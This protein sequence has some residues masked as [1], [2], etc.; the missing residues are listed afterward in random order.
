MNFIVAFIL[1]ISGS[2]EKEA[3]WF[4]AG[5]LTKSNVGSPQSLT[6]T[7]MCGISGFFKSGFRDLLEQIRI[8]HIYFKK[9]LP[10]L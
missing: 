8:F 4:F 3:F 10:K 7:D 5:L 2:R 9:H 1:M 6:I